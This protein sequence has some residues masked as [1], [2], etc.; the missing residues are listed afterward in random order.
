MRDRILKE[1]EIKYCYALPVRPTPG[2]PR[3]GPEA[4]A[5]LKS[6]GRPPPSG[7]WHQ[8]LESRAQVLSPP[9]P[10]KLSAPPPL[11]KDVIIIHFN[12]CFK[13]AYE[14]SKGDG[15]YNFVST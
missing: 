3:S 6:T 14:K 4:G 15:K 2:L 12:N 5:R 13:Y 7:R 11:S 10:S 8:T 9:Q 1:G